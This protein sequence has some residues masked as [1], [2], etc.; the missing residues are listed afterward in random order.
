MV[1]VYQILTYIKI[2]ENILILKQTYQQLEL[3]MFTSYFRSNPQKN[4][5]NKNW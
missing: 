3:K 1:V 4:Y 2:S 5:S